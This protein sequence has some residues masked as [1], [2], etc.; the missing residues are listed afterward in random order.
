M[1]VSFVGSIIA[2]TVGANSGIGHLIIV[3]SSRFDIPLM[4]AGLVVTSAMGVFMY[5]IALLVERH[6]LAWA[7]D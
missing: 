4:F 2:E 5:S 7:R 3:A 1:T 6:A